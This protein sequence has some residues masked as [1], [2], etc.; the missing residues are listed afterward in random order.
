MSTEQ[1]G[2]NVDNKN[3]I[4]KDNRQTLNDSYNTVRSQNSMTGAI[5]AMTA[6]E[7]TFSSAVFSFIEIAMSGYTAMAF[8]TS[9][10]QFNISG[11]L[12]AMSV[13]S[14]LNTVYDYTAGYS[15]K[16]SFNITLERCLLDVVCSGA[17][18]GELVL[19]KAR[20]P[21]RINL[22]AYETLNWTSRGKNKGK[23]PAQTPISGGDPILLDIATFFV[24][25]MHK[26]TPKAYTDSMMS[27]GMQQVFAFGEFVN[28]MRRAVRRN[29]VGRLTA[30]ID[31]VMIQSGMPEEIK[32]DPDKIQGWMD[33]HRTQV[34]LVLNGLNPEDALVF[35]D[36][37]TVDLL[38]ADGEKADYVPLLNALSG[39][40]ATALKSSPSILGLRLNGSQSLSN[41]E[42]LVFLKVAASIQRPVEEFMSRL[43]T[44]AVR[45][46]GIDV[47]VEF[48]F[49]PINLRPE[50][51]LE[52]FQTMRESRI[53][54]QL[55]EGFLSDDEAAWMMTGGPRPA[56]APPLSGSG[57][58]RKGATGI[59]ASKASPNADPQGRALQ[60]DTPS[61]AGGDSNGE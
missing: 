19:N 26:H 59:D 5:R 13:I 31:S 44:L 41:T 58:R 14:R 25:E 39:Q 36:Q 10:Q 45:L 6:R 48:K 54:D 21:D 12:A 43:L 53:L 27:A 15:D 32:K 37:V 51:E 60:P 28:E 55:S 20:L 1:P 24:A 52:A 22:V 3:Q 50:D 33:S 17:V 46:Y 47:Y 35:Y 16:P 11:A 7:G 23:Y 2:D 61:N 30:S 42:S 40:T 34:E 18:S 57:F 29:A 56:G 9:D 8:N 4:P 38:K 49:K